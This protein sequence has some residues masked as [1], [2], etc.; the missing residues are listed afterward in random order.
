MGPRPKLGLIKKPQKGY[1][2]TVESALQLGNVIHRGNSA[3]DNPSDL[4]PSAGPDPA[5]LNWEE[6]W[7]LELWPSLVA[8]ILYEFNTS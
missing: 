3:Q 2:A 8:S 1:A 5:R 4:G 7:P 6:A